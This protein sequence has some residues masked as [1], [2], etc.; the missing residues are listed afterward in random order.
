[1]RVDLPAPLGPRT[2]TCSP[3]VSDRFV[4]DRIGR[5][6]RM[7]TASRSSKTG[8]CVMRARRAG[9]RSTIRPKRPCR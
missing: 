5:P 7:T 3:S 9:P 4:T 2:A 1:M 6:C 8:S